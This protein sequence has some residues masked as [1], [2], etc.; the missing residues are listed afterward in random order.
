[1]ASPGQTVLSLGLPTEDSCRA[2]CPEQ[3][4]GP[5]RVPLV[6][7]HQVLRHATG[8]QYLLMPVHQL[9]LLQ[10][11]GREDSLACQFEVGREYV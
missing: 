7:V 8:P 9:T 6:P 10:A 5:A 4:R 2:E 3:Y 1:M 11:A